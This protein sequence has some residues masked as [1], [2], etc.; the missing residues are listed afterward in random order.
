MK[1]PKRREIIIAS[2]YLS[3]DYKIASKAIASRI[4]T[5]LPKLISDEQTEAVLIKGRCISDNISLLD[6][7]SNIQKEETFRALFF[8]SNLRNTFG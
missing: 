3:M 2:L 5:F 6:K 1:S 4:K 8:L 7:T